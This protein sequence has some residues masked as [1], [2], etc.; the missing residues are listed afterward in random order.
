MPLSKHDHVIEAF[1]ANASNEPFRKW[2]LPRTLRRREHFLNAHSLNSISEM[3]TVHPITIP[4]QITRCSIFRE[5]FD[6][7]LCGPFSRRMLR[8]IEMQHA[9]TF[10]CQHHEYEQHSQ[11]YRRNS[12]EVDRN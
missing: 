1:S 3:T 5:R 12:K 10:V 6:D 7:L 8:H 11:L 4:Y 2:I 9:T